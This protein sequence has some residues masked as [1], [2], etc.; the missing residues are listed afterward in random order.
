MLPRSLFLKRKSKKRDGFLQN[1]NA[2]TFFDFLISKKF[3][4]FAP[5]RNSDFQPLKFTI[6]L[7]ST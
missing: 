5:A 4:A 1:P 3:T 7:S 6:N 2:S